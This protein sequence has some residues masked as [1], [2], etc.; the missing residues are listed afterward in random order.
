MIRLLVSTIVCAL[1]SLAILL[2]AYVLFILLGA[3]I[4]G[5]QDFEET[6]VPITISSPSSEPTDVDLVFQQATERIQR[7]LK[8]AYFQDM[9]YSGKCKDLPYLRGRLVFLFVEVNPRLLSQQILSGTASVDT[10]HKTMNLYFTDESNH[11]HSTERGLFPG[12]NGV[13]EIAQL[14]HQHI[15]AL[16][17]CDGDVTITQ[18][19]ERWDVRCGPLENFITKCNF[20][21]IDGKIEDKLN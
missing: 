3:Y 5:F 8:G 1:G 21:I 11:Y 12:H 14:A 4:G 9:V 19:T 7:T 10:F 15:T 13:E 2:S 18:L 17:L 6:D 20:E 16:N